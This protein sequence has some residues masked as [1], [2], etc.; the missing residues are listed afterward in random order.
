MFPPVVAFSSYNLYQKPF[1]LSFLSSFSACVA[2]ILFVYITF[3]YSEL[4]SVTSTFLVLF[5]YAYF[6][7]LFGL[8]SVCLYLFSTTGYE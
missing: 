5:V 6:L 7:L 1:C 3:L 4:F 2:P 8:Y